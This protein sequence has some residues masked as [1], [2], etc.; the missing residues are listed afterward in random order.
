MSSQ[1]SSVILI[2]L[3]VNVHT[4]LLVGYRSVF[5]KRLKSIKQIYRLFVPFFQVLSITAVQ[6]METIYVDRNLENYGWKKTQLTGLQ[7]QYPGSQSSVELIHPPCPN[8]WA[9][10]IN[11]VTMLT[12]FSTH[13]LV[14]TKEE[15]VV[16][17][18]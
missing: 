18:I 2:V 9:I 14:F 12:P 5:A 1:V 3:F 11:D 6:Y 15:Y 13:T 7:P 16:Q 4:M 17:A 10:C 8:T